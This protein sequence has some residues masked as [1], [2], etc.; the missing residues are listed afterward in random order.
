MQPSL[1]AATRRP[2]LKKLLFKNLQ[3]SQG[4]NTCVLVS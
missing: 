4:N 2:H 3:Y 1:D